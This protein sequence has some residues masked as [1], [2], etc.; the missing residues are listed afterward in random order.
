M[1]ISEGILSPGILAAGAVLTAAGVIIGL[2]KIDT[3][4]IP[5]VGIMSAAFFVGS[6]VHVPIGPASVHLILNGLLGLIL[7][8]KAFPAILTG[9]L[10]QAL[11][12]QFGGI[13][14]L[15]V[16]TF[17]MALP[18]IACFYM[19]GWCVRSNR[20]RA[21][22]IAA[23]FG[24]G[25][26][27]VFFS[28]ILVALSLYLTGEAFLPTSKLILVAHLPVMFIEGGLTAV[29]ALFLKSVKPELLEGRADA[30]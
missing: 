28:A 26:F 20:N 7:G 16:N 6:L 21:L 3:E 14:S 15:G 18:A 12:F 30:F 1:H 2:K 27:A 13:T 24:S 29:C 23:S 5:S 17:N 10:L 22:F 9:L 19:F 4:D 25:F 11:L 8:W